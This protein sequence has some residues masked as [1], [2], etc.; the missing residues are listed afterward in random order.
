MDQH[1]ILI[2]D[3]EELLCVTIAGLLRDEGYKISI[4]HDGTGVMPVIEQGQVD[5]VLLDLMMPKMGGMETLA[6][7]KKQSPQ[8]RVIIL[9]GYGT[10][11]HVVQAEQLGS[12]GFINKPFGVETL[13]RRIKTVLG[14]SSR[15][16]FHEHDIE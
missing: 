1:H 7:V 11:E 14:S 4:V 3:D 12:D 16:P 15:S 2:A 8:T 5:L 10:S 9:S 13:V 6:L